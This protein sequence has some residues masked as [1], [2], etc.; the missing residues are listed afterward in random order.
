MFQSSYNFQPYD[1]TTAS[2]YSFIYDIEEYSKIKLNGD[3][4]TLTKDNNL[5]LPF[6]IETL[7]VNLGNEWKNITLE[8][9]GNTFLKIIK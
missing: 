4:Y 3:L 2:N 6:N 1:P 9:K 7:E 8:N 5:L